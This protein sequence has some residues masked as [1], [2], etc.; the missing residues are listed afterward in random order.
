MLVNHS[1]Q[2]YPQ[3]LAR[4]MSVSTAM[5]PMATMANVA[6]RMGS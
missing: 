5:P 6:M 1:L 3:S 4:V 2:R